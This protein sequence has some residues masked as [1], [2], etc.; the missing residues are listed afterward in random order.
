MGSNIQ[1]PMADHSLSVRMEGEEKSTRVPMRSAVLGTEPR[2]MVLSTLSYTIAMT[3]F[4]GAAIV[5]V[6][7]VP[8]HSTSTSLGSASAEATWSYDGIRG[9]SQWGELFNREFQECSEG[10]EQSPVDVITAAV[11][12]DRASAGPKLTV[13]YRSTHE[14]DTVTV[15]LHS[16][17]QSRG[18]SRGLGMGG[19]ARLACALW[20]LT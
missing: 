4:I 19:D 8:R 13:N 1:L 11:P 16:S 3:I 6:S 2:R 7:S 9:P 20:L 10:R 5:F 12:A 18:K 14:Q 17:P 15:S